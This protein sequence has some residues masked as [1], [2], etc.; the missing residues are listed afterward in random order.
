MEDL[1]RGALPTGF[2]AALLYSSSGLF[3]TRP[4]AKS[5]PEKPVRPFQEKKTTNAYPPPERYCASICS[6]SW[7]LGLYDPPPSPRTSSSVLKATWIHSPTFPFGVFSPRFRSRFVPRTPSFFRRYRN[8][9]VQPPSRILFRAPRRPSC[10]PA[11]SAALI[12]SR[13]P[14]SRSLTMQSKRLNRP[15]QPKMALL[16]HVNTP[17]S[18]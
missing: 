3:S 17:G 18:R 1:R 15:I 5:P 7:M 11:L 13:T 4:A 8:E 12:R 2:G 14:V 9:N 6:S 10:N 16:L